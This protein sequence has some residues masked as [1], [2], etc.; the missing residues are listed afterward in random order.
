MLPLGK[1][2][3]IDFLSVSLTL[4][5]NLVLAYPEIKPGQRYTP[6]RFSK[7]EDNFDSPK[8]IH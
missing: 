8:H 5:L 2:E 3:M 7:T 1:I 4:P 6:P